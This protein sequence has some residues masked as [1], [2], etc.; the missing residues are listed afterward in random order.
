M[1]ILIPHGQVRDLIR[2]ILEVD[3]RKRYT[4]S[5]VSSYIPINNDECHLIICRC[6]KIRKHPWY[7]IVPESSVPREV[8]NLTEAEQ[9]KAEIIKAIA[10]AGSLS[11]ATV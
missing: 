3:P 4:I 9:V 11:F 8:V 2:C 1:S 5:E 10:L 6:C 7:A